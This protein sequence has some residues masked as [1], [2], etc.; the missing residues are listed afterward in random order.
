[1]SEMED[2]WKRVLG[3]FDDWIYYETS[4]FGPWTS[5]FNMENLHE[6]TESQRLGWMYNMRDVVIP[7]RVD[8]CREAGVALEDFLPYMPDVDTI[9]VVQS[10]LD[11]ALRIQDGILHMS[12]AFDMMIE[13]YQKGG[14][15]DIGSALQAIA[16][17]EEDIRHY[18]S[19]FSQGF[20][21][22]KSLGLDLPEDLQ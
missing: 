3:A 20:G 16:E 15:E 14:L 9:Q 18:M 10:M 17:S 8:K 13:E 19:M 7:G 1:M 2:A 6:L 21:R 12:D 4:E 22:L 11:L 5:Y